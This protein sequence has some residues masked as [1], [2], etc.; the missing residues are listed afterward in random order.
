VA[1]GEGGVIASRRPVPP[2]ISPAIT[3]SAGG[4]LSAGS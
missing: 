3:E 4:R 2:P 1:G